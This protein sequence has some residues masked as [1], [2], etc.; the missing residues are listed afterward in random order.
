MSCEII[1]LEDNNYCWLLQIETKVVKAST[2]LAMFPVHCSRTYTIP[3][4]T[5]FCVKNYKRFSE[6]LPEREYRVDTTKPL[7][8]KTF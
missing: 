6:L 2:L 7:T 5:S 3:F 4:E 1:R 8:V